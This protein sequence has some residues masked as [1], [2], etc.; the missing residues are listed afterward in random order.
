[1]G[2]PFCCRLRLP[3]S[4][5]VVAPLA[6]VAAAALWDGPP[7]GEAL[8]LP[9]PIAQDREAARFVSCTQGGRQACV[10]DGDTIWYRGTKIR[11]A[12]VN[13][14]ETGQPRCTREGEL[15]AAATLRLTE[16]LNAGPFSLEPIDR[17]R[18]RYGRALRVI[19]RGGRS[20]GDTL[21]AEGLA[22]PW[23]GYRGNW[24]RPTGA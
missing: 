15:V 13:T 3:S 18:D 20:L 14:P 1:M 7:R 12:D 19:S 6:A 5:L 16:L 2:R 11:L 22:E 4:I 8:A 9:R 21:A 17:D 23:R 24:C 10:V